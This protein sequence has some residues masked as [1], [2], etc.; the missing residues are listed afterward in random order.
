MGDLNVAS[1]PAD[2]HPR[3][4]APQDIYSAEE[5]QLL[6]ALTRRWLHPILGLLRLYSHPVSSARP[7]VSTQEERQLLAARSPAGSCIHF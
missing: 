2:I 6:A 4:G 3:I 1:E 5:R 7:R